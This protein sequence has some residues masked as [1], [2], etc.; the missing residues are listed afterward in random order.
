M[1][2]CKKLKI[3]FVFDYHHYRCNNDGENYLDYIEEIFL[4]WK[5]LKPK[6]AGKADGKLVSELVNKKLNK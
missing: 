4:T 2:I 3:P 5:D 1:I 6:I